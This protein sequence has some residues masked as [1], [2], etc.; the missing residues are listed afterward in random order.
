VRHRVVDPVEIGAV[1]VREHIELVRGREHR[2]A[3]RIRKEFRELGF[4]R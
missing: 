1:V 3:P 2:V 4:E